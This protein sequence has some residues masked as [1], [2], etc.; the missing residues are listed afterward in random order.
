MRAARRISDLDDSEFNPF[1]ADE[2]LWGDI[3]DPYPVLA[4]YRRRGSVHNIEYR[5]IFTNQSDP[6]LSHY[7]TYSVFGYDQVQEVLTN[8]AKFSSSVL[9]ENLG[10]SFGRTVVVLDP[11][12][13]TRYRRIFQKAFLPNTVRKWVDDI[14][15]PIIG[16]LLDP[17]VSQGR[18]DLVQDF[19]VQFPFNIIYKQLGLPKEDGRVFHKLAISQLFW[20]THPVITAEAGR[21]LGEFFEEAV[22]ERR[23]QPTDDLISLLANAEIDGEHL[24][25]EQVIS[26][27]RQLINAAGDTTYRTTGTLMMCLLKNPEQLEAVR[28]DRSL[29]PAAIDEALRWDGPVTMNWRRTTG[30]LEL[31]G[32][33]IPAAS[34]INIVQGSA[35]RDETKFE[36]PDRYNIRRERKH[37]HFG[38]ATGPH[39]CIGQHL[40]KLEMERALTAILDRFPN[41]RLDPAFPE[42]VSRGFHLR[43]PRHVRVLFD[44]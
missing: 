7:P 19:T 22:A 43:T 38:F 2:L 26:F 21:K 23:A 37:R 25:E 30:D 40:A 24:P 41:L 1:V 6:T 34:V 5:R 4:D 12:E 15:D 17:F 32:T 11:P 10:L 13:H 9:M 20:T 29:I 39:V 35:N 18:M 36:E 42:P 14:I 44:S 3:E 31:G 27:L 8:P 33:D 16:E 28:R